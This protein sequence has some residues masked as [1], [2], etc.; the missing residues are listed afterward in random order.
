MTAQQ[1]LD[2]DIRVVQ[3][4]AIDIACIAGDVVQVAPD[5]WAIHG[6]TAVDGDVL[7]AEFD[8]VERATAVLR[9]LTFAP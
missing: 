2:A 5:V 4:L 9:G 8:S 6:F 1:Q 7:M 3:A